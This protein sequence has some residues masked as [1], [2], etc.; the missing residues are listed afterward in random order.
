MFAGLGTKHTIDYHSLV[1]VGTTNNSR[2]VS[3]AF[4]FPILEAKLKTLS[5]NANCYFRLKKFIAIM[6]R[7]S[8]KL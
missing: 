2:F 1:C 8:A 3:F 7:V 6:L 4:N 5:T